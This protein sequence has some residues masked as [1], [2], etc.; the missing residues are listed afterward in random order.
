MGQLGMQGQH[1]MVSAKI[2]SMLLECVEEVPHSDFRIRKKFLNGGIGK[3]GF[4][5]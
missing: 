5:E 2:Q 4:K 3:L 1:S